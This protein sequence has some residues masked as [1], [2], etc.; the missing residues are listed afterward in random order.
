M[1][2]VNSVSTG[3]KLPAYVVPMGVFIVL[4]AIL[5]PLKSAGDAFWLKSAE[6]WLFP[7]QTVIC[8]ALLIW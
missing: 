3:S 7:L 5:T 8:G 1:H 4:L 2:S 6:Y